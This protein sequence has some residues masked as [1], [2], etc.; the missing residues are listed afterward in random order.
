MKKCPFCAEEIQDEAI[1]CKHCKAWLRDKSEPNSDHFDSTPP[2]LEEAVPKEQPQDYR[3]QLASDGVSLRRSAFSPKWVAWISIPAVLVVGLIYVA[4]NQQIPVPEKKPHDTVATT[5][6][7]PQE[8]KKPLTGSSPSAGLNPPLTGKAKDIFSY[9]DGHFSF[10][11]PS[12][13]KRVPDNI[14]D[15]YAEKLN[16]ESKGKI[17]PP[18]YDVV[19]NR[20]E[21]SWPFERPYIMIKVLKMHINE[22]VISNFVSN[23]QK[24]TNK[25]VKK[26]GLRDIYKDSLIR[27]PIYDNQNKVIIY[28][29][30]SKLRSFDNQDIYITMIS[31]IFIYKDGVITINFYSNTKSIDNFMPDL[32]KILDSFTIDEAFKYK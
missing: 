23:I 10:I 17:K 9:P 25:I 20:K 11:L 7:L 1:K 21:A 24:E 6:E 26:D 13:W 31:S 19:F 15:E 30:D 14:V 8:K 27:E 22:I 5:P 4:I 18:K 16:K 12:G 2:L 28:S 32:K 29:A 3:T